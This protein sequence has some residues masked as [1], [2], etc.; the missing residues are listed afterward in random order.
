M[1]VKRYKTTTTII[2]VERSLA[3]CSSTCL[4]VLKYLYAY[5]SSVPKTSSSILT[6]FLSSLYSHRGGQIGDMMKQIKE[7]KNHVSFWYLEAKQCFFSVAF[8]QASGI[9]KPL[10]CWPGFKE[11]NGLH[12][13]GTTGHTHWPSQDTYIFFPA[14]CLTTI[15]A[16]RV[17]TDLCIV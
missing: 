3:T 2:V 1:L 17:C 6:T 4:F 7:L 10:P 13:F 9:R 8:N 15:D 11:D 12:E 5:V 16:F 14:R